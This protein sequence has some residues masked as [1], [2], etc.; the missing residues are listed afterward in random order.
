MTDL[1][2][3][4]RAAEG[5]VN[6][7][8]DVYGRYWKR[9]RHW[10]AGIVGEQDA[11]DVA[12]AVFLRLW[13]GGL[14]V[15]PDPS[16]RHAGGLLRHFSRWAAFEHQRRVRREAARYP[17]APVSITVDED[18]HDRLDDGPVSLRSLDPSPEQVAYASEQRAR[19][20]QAFRSLPRRTQRVAR[21][22]FLKEQTLPEIS[23][24]LAVTAG[25]AAAILNSA[26]RRLRKDLAPIYRRTGVPAHRGKAPEGP[27]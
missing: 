22:W 19:L 8:A 25:G 14:R 21:R 11:D 7:F 16:Y 24:E 2:L 6:A 26:K 15:E 12:Q 3:L 10:A 5:D 23:E 18:G 1:D 4:A 27:A 13:S 17:T 9:V 20:V